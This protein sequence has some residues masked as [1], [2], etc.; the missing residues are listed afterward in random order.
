MVLQQS[1]YTSCSKL[2]PRKVLC[3]LTILGKT[4]VITPPLWHPLFCIGSRRYCKCACR[5]LVITKTWN[6]DISAIIFCLEFTGFQLWF[7]NFAAHWDDAFWC[8][9]ELNFCVTR[10][11]SLFYCIKELIDCI[12]WILQY[13]IYHKI[14]SLS[15]NQRLWHQHNDSLLFLMTN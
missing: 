15:A 6:N 9:E 14:F 1:I 12:W 8:H 13:L 5:E 2:R 3:S 7:I 11:P 10:P 4:Q